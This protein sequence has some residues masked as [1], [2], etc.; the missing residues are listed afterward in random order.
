MIMDCKVI[1]F[2]GIDWFILSNILFKDFNENFG[3]MK[4]ISWWIEAVFSFRTLFP[5]VML[6]TLL[7]CLVYVSLRDCNDFI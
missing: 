1:G 5:L 7:A 2:E 6:S 3:S 4:R